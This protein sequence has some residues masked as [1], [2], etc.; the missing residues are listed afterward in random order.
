MTDFILTLSEKSYVDL[1]S[2]CLK[3]KHE[4]KLLNSSK[5]ETE[6]IDFLLRLLSY[7]WGINIA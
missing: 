6:T 4:T 2:D 5:I 7:L 1:V 3:L